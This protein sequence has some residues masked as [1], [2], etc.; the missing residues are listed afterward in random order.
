MTQSIP[1]QVVTVLNDDRPDVSH[2]VVNVVGAQPPDDH[3]DERGADGNPVEVALWVVG[4]PFGS[5]LAGVAGAAQ[6]LA[7][8]IQVG[9]GR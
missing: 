8:V 1:T 9:V 3:A 6:E 7:D 4:W 2:L 5:R